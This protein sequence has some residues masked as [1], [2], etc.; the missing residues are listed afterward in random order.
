MTVSFIGP[1]MFSPSFCLYC[2]KVLDF[3]K[4]IQLHSEKPA[5]ENWNGYKQGSQ[6]IY[7]LG[8]SVLVCDEN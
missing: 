1:R 4:K 3:V 7:S 8:L 2:T 6:S 5:L